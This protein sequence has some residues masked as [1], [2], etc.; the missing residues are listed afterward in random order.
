MHP[1]M[2]SGCSLV[3]KCVS[4]EDTNSYKSSYKRLEGHFRCLWHNLLKPMTT[5][6]LHEVV[7]SLT[8]FTCTH[9][10]SFPVLEFSSVDV[11]KF[12]VWKSIIYS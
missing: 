2:T 3:P 4:R 5:S 12:V 9:S 8:C 11:T 7:Q 10:G 6:E 1:K